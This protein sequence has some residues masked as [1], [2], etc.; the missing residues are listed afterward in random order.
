MSP[1]QIIPMFMLMRS[2]TVQPLNAS[3]WGKSLDRP[4]EYRIKVLEIS[5]PFTSKFVFSLQREAE[6]KGPILFLDY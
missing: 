6:E 1:F 5:A 4:R 3:G 2:L